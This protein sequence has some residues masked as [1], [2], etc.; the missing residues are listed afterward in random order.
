MGLCKECCSP[1]AQVFIA[2]FPINYVFDLLS[3]EGTDLRSRPLVERHELL[4]KLL[5]KAPPYIRLSEELRGSKEDLLQLARQFPARRPERQKAPSGPVNRD[6]AAFA[7]YFRGV[8][9]ASEADFN[10]EIAEF[11]HLIQLNPKDE[12]A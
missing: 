1:V 12:I 2:R 8:A 7:Y 5:K 3:R 4:A 10:G 6:F 11:N 9:K